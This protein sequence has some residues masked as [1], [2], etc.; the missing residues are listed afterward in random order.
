MIIDW[1]VMSGIL[2]GINLFIAILGFFKVDRLDFEARQ[3]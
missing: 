2:L 1:M 3:I